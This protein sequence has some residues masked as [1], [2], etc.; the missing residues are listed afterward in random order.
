MYTC[1]Y[2]LKFYRNKL[3]RVFKN[4]DVFKNIF[5][6]SRY[7]IH[8]CKRQNF[9]KGSIKNNLALLSAVI[10]IIICCYLH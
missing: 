4:K 1:I 10:Y 8:N 9:N 5:N 2:L 6:R 3:K 7:H